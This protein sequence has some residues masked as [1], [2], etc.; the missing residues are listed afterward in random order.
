MVTTVVFPRTTAR[1]FRLSI[2]D[3]PFAPFALRD[4]VVVQADY[5]CGREE[6]DPPTIPRSQRIPLPGPHIRHLDVFGMP[7]FPLV[8]PFPA[9]LAV[10][11]TPVRMLRVWSGLAG[12]VTCRDGMAAV[13]LSSV[14][15]ANSAELRFFKK[16]AGVQRTVSLDLLARNHFPV[17]CMHPTVPSPRFFSLAT[18]VISRRPLAGRSA[19]RVGG[20][21]SRPAVL[22]CPC[23]RAERGFG[24]RP[25]RVAA[26]GAV[27]VG[28]AG[29]MHRSDG[30]IAVWTVDETPVLLRSALLPPGVSSPA[31]PMDSVR[32]SAA[33]DCVAVWRA[34]ETRGTL[35]LYTTHLDLRGESAIRSV[36][37]VE[38]SNFGVIAACVETDA[39]SLHRFDFCGTP[40][41]VLRVEEVV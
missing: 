2:F 34:G 9:E 18:A 28:T 15:P 41:G 22:A 19:A 32:V 11:E 20:R 8:P 17:L 30:Q 37:S 4:R 12:R 1:L 21:N 3:V 33:L 25:G 36:L 6:L 13:L 31:A 35:L 38:I 10:A 29:W 14:S 40:T 26:G 16:T 5:T 7:L 39:C 27:E 24:G 23:L